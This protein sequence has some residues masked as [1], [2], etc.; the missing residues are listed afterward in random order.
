MIFEI[1]GKWDN[2]FKNDAVLFLAQS[3]EK[4]LNPK[5]DH[6]NRLPVL[7]AYSLLYE[8][9]KTFDL[10]EKELIDKQHLDFISEEMWETLEH[11]AIVNTIVTKNE[12]DSIKQ[13]FNGAPFEEKKTIIYYLANKLYKFNEKAKEYLLEN[14]KNEKNKT[15]IY[16]ALKSYLAYLIGGGYSEDFI[17]HFCK[18]IFHNKEVVS[19][20]T[21]NKFL[22]RFDFTNQNYIVILPVNLEIKQFKE[23]L[24]KRLDLSFTFNR[25][26]RKNFKYDEDKYTL[27]SISVSALDLDCASVN[28]MKQLSLFTRYY[29]FF[30]QNTVPFFGKSC[31]VINS[32]SHERNIIKIKK[33]GLV[34]LSEDGSTSKTQMGELAESVITTL[35]SMDD[36]K[37]FSVIDKAIINYNNAYENKDLKSSYLNFW[38]VL[39]SFCERKDSSKISQIEQNIL[40]ILTKDYISMIFKD[41]LKDIENN[42]S[43]DIL[44]NFFTKIF[45]KSKLSNLEFISFILLDEYKENRSEFNSLLEN[46]PFIRYKIFNINKKYKNLG[47]IKKDIDRFESRIK[48]HLRRLYRARNSII[49]S[50]ER[51]QHLQ[52][53]S[54]HLMEYTS[55]F[56]DEIIFNLT[57][58][59]DINN[60]ESLFLDMELYN[61]NLKTYLSNNSDKIITSEAIIFLLSYKES[62]DAD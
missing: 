1:T 49:H 41:L 23:I 50:G 35:L 28:A 55:Q 6:V 26:Q 31:I 32:D 30:S 59:K 44:N 19:L 11:D 52:Y 27:V 7:N 8:Y 17:Y 16:T 46:Y 45:S 33:N 54:K 34:S 4:L 37:V 2:E 29:K 60:V 38:S 12:M 57:I 22:D 56:L 14:V 25:Y 20:E 61:K 42:V 39:E 18:K 13:K 62:S 15:E 40:P 43:E 58:R 24:E 53:L 48:W 21:V 47:L 3:I 10:V 36:D 9:I 5:T 51:P